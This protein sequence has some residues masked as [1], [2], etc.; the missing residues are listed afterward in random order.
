MSELKNKLFV[1]ELLDVPIINKFNKP[2]EKVGFISKFIP[3]GMKSIIT[4]I[5]NWQ[6]KVPVGTNQTFVGRGKTI[7]DIVKPLDI[8]PKNIKKYIKPY[9]VRRPYQM[10]INSLMAIYTLRNE[11]FIKN[12]TD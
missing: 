8:Y 1:K 7:K 4:A 5:I 2:K 12:K 9:L 11:V 3:I 10:N 6:S